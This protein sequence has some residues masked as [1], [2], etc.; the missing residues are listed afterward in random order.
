MSFS[1]SK[2]PNT[3]TLISGPPVDNDE[4]IENAKS[5]LQAVQNMLTTV[6]IH[7]ISTQHFLQDNNL[8][9]ETYID[10]LKISKRGPNVILQGNPQDVLINACNHDMLSLWGGNVDLQYVINEMATVKYVCSYMTKGEKGMGETLKRVAKECQNDAI[11]TQRNKIKKV[12]LGKQ[13]LGAPE[14]AM[15]VWSRRLMKK[16]RKV[17]PVMTSMKD[18]HASLPKPQSQLAQLHDDDEDIFATSLVERYAARPVSLQNMYLAKFAVTYHVIQFATK[19]EETDGVNDKEEE[20][21]K[22]E[23]N[24]SVTMIILQKRL[25]VIRKR[26]WK[27]I[28]CTR[29]Y[30]IHAESEKYYHAKLL[31]NYP[32]K[33]EDD[34]ISPFT[35]YH[36][37][38]I[39]KQDVIHQN[40]KNSVKT[41]WHSTW[42]CKIWKTRYHSLHGRW[43]LQI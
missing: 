31:L 13:V 33:N 16:S 26:K 3:K 23:N 30:K 17:V 24:N 10:A 5:V 29:R 37:A 32:W 20:M 18:E 15:Q 38:Y 2:T 41:V 25:G 42:T 11:Q 28:L 9:V 19:K 6:D 8:D 4:I 7:N 36:E 1:F 27:A 22:T 39:S 40:A 34:I 12:F 35:T 14:S 43:L 21:Q